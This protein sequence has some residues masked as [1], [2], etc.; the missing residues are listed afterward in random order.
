MTWLI[1]LGIIVVLCVLAYFTENKNKAVRKGSLFIIQL[2]GYATGAVFW[3]LI[4]AVV[5]CILYG[6]FS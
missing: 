4:A 6:V 2:F 5:A 3:L 1:A